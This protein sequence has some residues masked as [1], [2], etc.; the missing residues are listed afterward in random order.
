MGLTGKCRRQQGC[1][2]KR[3]LGGGDI[4]KVKRRRRIRRLP[5]GCLISSTEKTP[6]NNAQDASDAPGVVCTRRN[7]GRQH[8]GASCADSSHNPLRNDISRSGGKRLP[9]ANE[10]L[11]ARPPVLSTRKVL[12]DT[13][14]CRRT[15]MSVPREAG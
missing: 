1:T 12:Q 11:V 7:P 9:R 10:K 6:V 5:I 14:P 4:P 3:Q 8:R 13:R 15:P 2:R